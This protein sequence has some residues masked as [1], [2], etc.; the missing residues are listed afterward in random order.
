MQG[1]AGVSLGAGREVAPGREEADPGVDSFCFWCSKR[2]HNFK[3]YNLII[4]D[5]ADGK[6]GFDKV[7]R[8][9]YRKDQD[10]GS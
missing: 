6:V 5:S 10:R 4:K 7:S 9:F 8:N 2:R 1:G 3:Q